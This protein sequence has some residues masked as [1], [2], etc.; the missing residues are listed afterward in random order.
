MKTDVV[1]LML[2][3]L[4]QACKVLLD[5]AGSSSLIDAK[6]SSGGTALM[7]AG[8]AGYTDVVKLL[9]ERGAGVNARVQVTT[10]YGAFTKYNLYQYYCNLALL[11]YFKFTVSIAII[12]YYSIKCNIDRSD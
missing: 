5:A 11:L 7:F 4:E 2:H 1:L 9:L 3:V 12:S 10:Q 6:A 8:A